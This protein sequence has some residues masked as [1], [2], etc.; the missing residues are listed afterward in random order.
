MRGASLIRFMRIERGVLPGFSLAMGFTLVYLLLMVVL[1]LIVMM[2]QASQI[3]WW[4]FWDV[5]LSPRVLSAYRVSFGLSFVAALIN[6]VFG[7]IVAWVLARYQFY[8]KAFFDSLIDLPFAL[9]TSIAG[10]ALASLY[11]AAWMVGE[12]ADAFWGL[13]WRLRRR[14]LLWR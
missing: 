14:V 4:E 7:T 11:C 9:P 3:G 1:P 2:I 5:I 10:I 6:S 12:C 8:G 13:R